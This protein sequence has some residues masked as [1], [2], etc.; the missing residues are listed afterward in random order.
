[1]RVL[2]GQQ[3]R[4][5]EEI[6]N[7]KG[8]SYE[9]MMKIAGENFAKILADKHENGGLKISLVCGRGKNGG[10]GFVAARYLA[11][12]TGHDIVLVLAMGEPA[13]ELSK[14]MYADLEDAGLKTFDYTKTSKEALAEISAANII[15]DAIFGIGF[16]GE[17]AGELRE[18]VGGMNMSAAKVYALDIPSGLLC[19]SNV[20]PSCH[21]KA[22]WTIT[23]LAPKPA[24]VLKP[25]RDFCG[26]LCLV[27]IG[28]DEDI[29]IQADS[30]FSVSDETEIRQDFPPRP[31]GSH[32][33]SFGHVL[34]ICGSYQMPGAAVLA[35]RAAVHCGAGLVT[36]AF[37]EPAYS[38]IASKLTEPL[39]LPLKA[40]TGGRISSSEIE[41]LLWEA[42]KANVVLLGCGLGNDEDTRKVTEKLIKNLTCPL[43][44]DADGINA[45][46]FDIC[47]LKEAKGQILMTPHP[48][49]M[50][51]LSGLSLEEILE[52][53]L[54]IARFFAKEWQVTL[55]LKGANT[56]IADPEGKCYVN[57][58]GNPLLSG[59]GSGDVLSGMIAAFVAQGLSP[60]RAC[61]SAAYMHGLAAD[62]HLNE[63]PTF[64]LPATE[65]I[66][67]IPFVL[68]TLR[69]G[70]TEDEK[71]KRGIFSNFY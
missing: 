37:P 15:I 18:L 66:E 59:G 6:A 26:E 64:S 49:E 57:T 25:T 12:H 16:K 44:L 69:K 43:I 33:G 29:L 7:K 53:P 19:D 9:K 20:L 45:L 32:K 1:M 58:T 3:V 10:D 11:E 42:E 52:N 21:I 71:N 23:M 39:L 51:R 17:M 31:Y 50:S 67:K 55:L 63:T 56:V 8:L 68:S 70:Q 54:E 35:A 47:L 61:V 36:A 30:A 46:S 4:A 34:S 41:R 38:A 28:V 2:T 24:L 60:L 14:K 65:L 48:G 27:D 5:V 62:I 22:D 40:N 13:D